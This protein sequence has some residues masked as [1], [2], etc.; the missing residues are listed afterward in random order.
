MERFL[1]V[2]ITICIIL[3]MDP[4]W[5]MDCVMLLLII[6][7]CIC[8]ILRF[9]NPEKLQELT[10]K[11]NEIIDTKYGGKCYFTKEEM[12]YNVK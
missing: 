8:G 6:G 7:M 9:S 10:D 5:T 12:Y 1:W 2:I 3:L 4:M 11:I